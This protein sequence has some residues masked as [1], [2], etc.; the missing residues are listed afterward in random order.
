MKKIIV[1]G[2]GL[3]GLTAAYYL[4]KK[5]YQITL[6]EASPKL[7]GRTYSLINEKFDDEFDNG[8]HLMMGCY[9]A[10][11]S[12]INELGTKDK[13]E[14]QKKLSINFID[15]DSCKFKLEARTN[16][17]PL[18]LLLAILNYKA[19][20]LRD[21]FKV[22]D[23]ILDIAC[24]FKEDLEKL[25]VLEWIL[26]KNQNDETINK[27][28]EI[29][30]VG[31]MNCTPEKASA[32]IFSNVLNEIFLNGN[33]SSKIILTN[34]G[35][36]QI[37]IEPIKQNLINKGNVIR[38]SERLLDI[39]I[40]ENRVKKISTNKNVYE[41]FD[42]I[43]IATPPFAISKFNF[44][45][46][47]QKTFSP[48]SQI[49]SYDFKYSSILNIHLWLRENIFEEKFY[50]LL[51]SE[52]HWLFNHGKHISLTKSNADL[53]VAKSN[54]EILEIVYSELKNYFTIFSKEKVIDVKIIK[55]KRATFI[56][57]IASNVLRSRIISEFDNLHF[58]GDWTTK[59][60]P[61]TIEGAILS[62]KKISE[63]I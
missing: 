59:E 14:I 27:L 30:V 57:D 58:I 38:T 12:L 53:L 18:N 16:F 13:I 8:Q 37:F 43:I 7:G 1:V 47:N 11:L 54:E 42:E 21:R 55:E 29:L 3:S 41:D 48:L 9:L 2:G 25:T 28:W 5:N 46:E 19:L 15:E 44:M 61:A 34:G 60:F 51:N 17:Y 45:N 50:G 40:E 39:I 32:L 22:I 26:L 4:S 36:S 35:L 10:T 23:F 56:P 31:T 24:C 52:I 62:G 49:L 6:I 33:S 63:M 20:S